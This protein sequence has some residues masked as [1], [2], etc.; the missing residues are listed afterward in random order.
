MQYFEHKSAKRFNIDLM[1]IKDPYKSRSV[2]KYYEKNGHI[3]DAIELDFHSLGVPAGIHSNILYNITDVYT[4]L[5][6]QFTNE[7]DIEYSINKFDDISFIS[8]YSILWKNVLSILLTKE[9][10]TYE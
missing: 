8:M 5:K 7:Y 1:R 4:I 3:V 2:W 9:Q 6:S 10:F